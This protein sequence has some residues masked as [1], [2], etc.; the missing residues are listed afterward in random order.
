M[1][2][3]RKKAW[4]VASGFF[5]TERLPKGYTKSE[6]LDFIDRHISEDYQDWDSE[7]MYCEINDLAELLV[8]FLITTD[9]EQTDD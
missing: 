3:I 7:T 5:L 6:I 2:N 4:I 8:T 9:L 1:E